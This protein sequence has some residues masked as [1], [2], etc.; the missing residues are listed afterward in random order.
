MTSYR[1]RPALCILAFC[2]VG[3]TLVWLLVQGVMHLLGGP[4]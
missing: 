2:L 3:W 4:A 1:N